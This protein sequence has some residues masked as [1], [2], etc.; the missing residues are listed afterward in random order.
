MNS[1]RFLFDYYYHVAYILKSYIAKN[2]LTRFL[3]REPG[4]AES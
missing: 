4:I 3:F 1:L 2:A